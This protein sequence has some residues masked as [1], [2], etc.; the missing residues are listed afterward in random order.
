MTGS[1][2]S[3]RR[4]SHSQASSANNS[5]ADESTGPSGAYKKIIGRSGRPML[6]PR[7]RPQSPPSAALS[8]A[9]SE[10]ESCSELTLQLRKLGKYLEKKQSRSDRESSQVLDPKMDEHLVNIRRALRKSP[11][12]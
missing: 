2:L 1:K 3:L 8:P 7:S 6:H 5:S 10:S 12:K 9:E 4:P 11:S